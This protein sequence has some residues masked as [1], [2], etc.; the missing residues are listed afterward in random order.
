G[1]RRQ[2]EPAFGDG[3]ASAARLRRPRTRAF[4]RAHRTIPATGGARQHSNLPAVAGSAVFPLASP[5]ATSPVAQAADRFHA[6][7]HAAQSGGVI[8]AGRF[9]GGP[10][11]NCDSR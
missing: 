4:E 9:G 11:S 5:A 10:I 7:E 1:G 3:A 2:M 6:E 8:F